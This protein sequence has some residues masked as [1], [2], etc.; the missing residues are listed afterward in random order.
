MYCDTFLQKIVEKNNAGNR[1][2]AA[3]SLPLCGKIAVLVTRLTRA[4]VGGEW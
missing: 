4:E 2:I 3:V 1:A